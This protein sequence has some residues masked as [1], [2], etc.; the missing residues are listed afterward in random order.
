MNTGWCSNP[1]R[2][3]C[4]WSARNGEEIRN[5]E[6]QMKG[7]SSFR[8]TAAALIV[9]AAAISGYHRHKAEKEGEEEISFR[10]EGL[11]TAVA[12]RSSGLALMLSVVAYVL[13]PRWMKW[14]SLDLPVWLRWSGAGLGTASLPLALWVFR[15]IGKNITPTVETRE[16]HELVTGGPSVGCGI[17]Y[18]RSG[19]RSLCR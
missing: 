4:G 19:P 11:P 3:N 17:P 9:A 14:S 7:E 12:L 10:E 15:T 1:A 16:R 6:A 5:E 13:N 18:T 8:V 2:A